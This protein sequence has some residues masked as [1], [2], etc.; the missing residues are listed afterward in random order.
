MVI[1]ASLGNGEL[2]PLPPPHQKEK[3][4]VDNRNEKEQTVSRLMRLLDQASFARRSKTR[5]Q[6]ARGQS[7]KK[8]SHLFARIPRQAEVRRSRHAQ[9][10]ETDEDC[11]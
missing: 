6:S 8:R 11:L 9:P 3:F 2:H 10:K 1:D 4:S 7:R 5:V